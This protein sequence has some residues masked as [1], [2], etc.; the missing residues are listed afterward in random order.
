MKSLRARAEIVVLIKE[1][2]WGV[3]GFRIRTETYGYVI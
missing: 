2:K 1:G 3:E